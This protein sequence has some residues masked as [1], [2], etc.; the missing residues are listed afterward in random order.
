MELTKKQQEVLR[1]YAAGHS[2]RNIE[3]YVD[4]ERRDINK[5]LDELGV[6]NSAEAFSILNEDRNDVDQLTP[7]NDNLPNAGQEVPEFKPEIPNAGKLQDYDK[8]KIAERGGNNVEIIPMSLQQA[9]RM[10]IRWRP[11]SEVKAK[12]VSHA[13]S[14]EDLKRAIK[15]MSP[16]AYKR[17]YGDE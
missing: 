13:G 12:W 7:S 11:L 9:F 8:R 17:F 1:W 14:E 6:T 5:M 2:I 16:S 10:D 3:Q 15:E 4:M